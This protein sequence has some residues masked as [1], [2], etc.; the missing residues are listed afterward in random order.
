[1]NFTENPKYCLKWSCMCST[2]DE[3]INGRDIKCKKVCNGANYWTNL[4][5]ELWEDAF[6]TKTQ[7]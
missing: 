5:F 3:C 2:N 7:T 6:H 1:M 4:W